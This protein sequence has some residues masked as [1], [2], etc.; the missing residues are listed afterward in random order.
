[1]ILS[2]DPVERHFQIIDYV[3]RIAPTFCEAINRLQL[4]AGDLYLDGIKISDVVQQKFLTQ[5][6]RE[7]K[8]GLCYEAA[9]L[10]M[11]LLKNNPTA[12]L[13]QG[14]AKY[15]ENGERTDH[16]WV[17]FEENGVPFA[18]D[19]TWFDE[20]I[21]LPQIVHVD[22]CESLVYFTCNYQQFWQMSMS[23]KLYRLCHNKKT[24]FVTPWLFSYRSR[25]HEYGL[26]LANLSEN[27]CR[28]KFAPTGEKDQFMY[29][30]EHIL[31]NCPDYFPI[32]LKHVAA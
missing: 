29:F 2:G 24:S 22:V 17:E 28:S 7:A 32:E 13:I 20:E 21:C 4:A 10:A 18:I 15:S 27:I 25:Q 16:A 8:H 5:L 23:Q 9:A 11:L 30:M 3:N 12:R 19:L 1:M 26:E 14:T 6:G 31:D